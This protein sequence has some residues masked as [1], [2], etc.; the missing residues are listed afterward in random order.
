MILPNGT[1]VR[2]T[3]NGP[4]RGC[5]G[6]ITE[7]DTHAAGHHIGYR[8]TL[9]ALPV[10]HRNCRRERWPFGYSEVEPEESAGPASSADEEPGLRGPGR[11]SLDW[12]E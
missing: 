10:S 4:F 6:V 7:H 11:T 9:D 12:D 3:E 5:H 2:I 8:V 1:R